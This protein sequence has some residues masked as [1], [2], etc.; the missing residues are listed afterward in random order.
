MSLTA[1]KVTVTAS[2]A[3]IGESAACKQ[4]YLSAPSANTGSVFVGGK[5]V[6]A[7]A[8]YPIPKGTTLGPITTGDIGGVYV[9]GTAEDKLNVLVLT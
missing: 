5:G 8:G 2:A 6:T 9:I 1:T 4:V 3:Q 7:E